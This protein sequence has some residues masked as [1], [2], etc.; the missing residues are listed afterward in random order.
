MKKNIQTTF[1]CGISPK[2]KCCRNFF[3]SSSSYVSFQ[4][5]CNPTNI[6]R[7]CSNTRICPRTDSI[8]TVFSQEKKRRN[9]IFTAGLCCCCCRSPIPAVQLYGSGLLLLFFVKSV[10]SPT[11]ACHY[12]VMCCSS[13]S[14]PVHQI[15]ATST[16]GGIE[17]QLPWC[18]SRP[19]LIRN[20]SATLVVELRV[21]GNCIIRAEKK[22]NDRWII[23][24]R[25][26]SLH[27]C[28]TVDDIWDYFLL[29]LL[30]YLEKKKIN[31]RT[32]LLFFHFSPSIDT[33]ES[34]RVVW[35]SRRDDDVTDRFFRSC[36]CVYRGGGEDWHD[37]IHKPSKSPFVMM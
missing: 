15:K 9:P 6:I 30:Y 11:V 5:G 29:L 23:L 12:T 35:K 26:E 1:H 34:P 3:L 2:N 28:Q 22:K 31:V 33:G 24:P 27:W 8:A 10:D 4:A 20:A 37:E 32:L 7:E 36:V 13:S 18:V 16:R 14:S 19:L 25:G 21:G 17:Q